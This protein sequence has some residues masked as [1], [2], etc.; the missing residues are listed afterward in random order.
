MASRRI[1]YRAVKELEQRETQETS[2]SHRRTLVAAVCALGIAIPVSVVIPAT[3]A[4]AS[5]ACDAIGSGNSW[6]VPYGCTSVLIPGSH[7]CV[8]LV[9]VFLSSGLFEEADECADIYAQNTSGV[10]QVWGVGEFYCQGQY[11]QCQGM[12]VTVDMSWSEGS[13]EA[14]TT[15]PAHYKCNPSP[16]PA[17]PGGRKPVS[18][19]RGNADDSGAGDCVNT[20]SWD[21]YDGWKGNSEVISIKPDGTAIH[22]GAELDSYNEQVCFLDS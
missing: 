21:P 6:T 5:S 20:Y 18:T 10:E 11:T 13:L 4:H 2:D 16:G 9:D 8:A 3:A 19:T 22:T 14:A 7:K 12:N 1:R 15:A 17:C